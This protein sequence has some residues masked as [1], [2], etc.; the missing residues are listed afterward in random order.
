MRICKLDVQL[1]ETTK[2]LRGERDKMTRLHRHPSSPGEMA[3]ADLIVQPR[4]ATTDEPSGA[5]SD[6]II[7]PSRQAAI[8]RARD[9]VQKTPEMRQERIHQ[10]SQA[11]KIGRLMLD[12]E[13]LADNLIGTQLHDLQSA[14]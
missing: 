3:R 10:L 7:L 9:V 14:A 11:V 1:H 13:L 6:A 5:T 8:R 4:Q 12:S 2:R